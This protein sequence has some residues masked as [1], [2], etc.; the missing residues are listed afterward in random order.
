MFRLKTLSDPLRRGGAMCV[1]FL[2][3]LALAACGAR[4][5]AP[6]S[7]SQ[8]AMSGQSGAALFARHCASCH[9]AQAEGRPQ[10][11]PALVGNEFVEARSDEELLAF[12]VAGRRVNDPANRTGIPMPPR[13]GGNLD[14]EQLAAVIA[15]LRGLAR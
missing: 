7:S 5:S 15:W 4:P 13:G 9:G 11:G 3:L 1:L 2:L 14:D 8:T 12:L 10:V 6:A